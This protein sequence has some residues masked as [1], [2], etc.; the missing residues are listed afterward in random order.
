MAVVQRRIG[1]LFAAGFCLLLLAGARTLYLGALQGGSLRKAAQTQQVR[2][3]PVPAQRGSISDRTGLDLAVSEPAQDISVTP[4]LIRDPLTVAQRLAPLL[5]R[6]PQVLL[7]RLSERAGFVYL[8][9][10]VPA[11]QARAALALKIAGVAGTPV[12]RRV[13]PR[14]ALAAQVLGLVGTE[15]RGLAGLE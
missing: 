1:G 9:R 14:G 8:A 4:Y 12:M 3:E 6:S 7:R 15:G 10:G 11:A 13:Y 2:N 5:G